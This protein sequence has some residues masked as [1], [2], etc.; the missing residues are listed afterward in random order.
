ML[1]TVENHR[2]G[3]WRMADQ[4]GGPPA[5]CRLYSDQGSCVTRHGRGRHL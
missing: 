5:S 2:R 1:D 4:R 3:G